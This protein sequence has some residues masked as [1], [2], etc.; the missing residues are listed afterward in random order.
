MIWVLIRFFLSYVFCVEVILSSAWKANSGERDCLLLCGVGLSWVTFLQF[1]RSGFRTFL[2]SFIFSKLFFNFLLFLW[3]EGCG[4]F[5][6]ESSCG[7]GSSGFPDCVGGVVVQIWWVNVKERGIC[8]QVLSLN[9]VRAAGVTFEGA[10]WLSLL[11]S[12]LWEFEFCMVHVAFQICAEWCIFVLNST[13]SMCC[14]CRM[15]SYSTWYFCNYWPGLKIEGELKE[16]GYLC[17]SSLK[18]VCAVGVTFEGVGC[19]CLRTGLLQES[20]ICMSHVAF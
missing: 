10:K 16:E 5:C 8:A 15:S 7:I 11:T 17:L 12:L 9:L 18:L 19:L 6:C 14:R 3:W 1:W 2:L 20:K 13:A 4:S